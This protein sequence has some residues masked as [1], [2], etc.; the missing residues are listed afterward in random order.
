MNTKWR[1]IEEAWERAEPDCLQ[2]ARKEEPEATEDELEDLAYDI[3]S[4]R[5]DF[6]IDTSHPP[7]QE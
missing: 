4:E 3:F 6:Y 2:Q 7:K 5:V 1:E